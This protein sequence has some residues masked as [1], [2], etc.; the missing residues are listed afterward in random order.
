MLIGAQNKRRGEL[1]D[2]VKEFVKITADMA[3]LDQAF[4]ENDNGGSM[5]RC[6]VWLI[7]L[8]TGGREGFGRRANAYKASL[9]KMIEDHTA[10]I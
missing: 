1:E 4:E 8:P 9:Q 10:D 5:A 7:G 3:K 2:L 6:V